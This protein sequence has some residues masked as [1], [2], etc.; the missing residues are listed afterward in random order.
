MKKE[1]ITIKTNKDG[2]IKVKAYKISDGLFLHKHYR[3]K[4]EFSN[5]NYWTITHKTGF[6]IKD[7][8]FIPMRLKDAVLECNKIKHLDWNKPY[9]FF[10][11]EEA[12]EYTLAVRFT[13]G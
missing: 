9:G 8:S 3:G 13:C 6:C 11:S 2:D 4:G 12:R 1:I 7:F 10:L 5:L